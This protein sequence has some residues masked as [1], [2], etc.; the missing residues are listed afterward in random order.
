MKQRIVLASLLKTVDDPRMYYKFAGSISQEDKYDINIVGFP[1]NSEVNDPSI[2]F[3]A[4]PPFSRKSFKRWV[5]RIHAA[6]VIWNLKPDLL[7]ITTHELLGIGLFCRFFRRSKLIYDIQ[8]NYA[9]NFRYGKG[10]IG[11]L[12]ASMIRTM[13]LISAWFIDHFILAE[14]CYRNE[15]RF[16]RPY[17][18]LENRALRPKSPLPIHITFKQLPKKFV[19][20][21]TLAKQTGVLDAIR[22]IDSYRTCVPDASLKIAGN[23][24]NRVFLKNLKD[25]IHSVHWIE[26]EI[27]EHPI[28]YPRV[29][30][31]IHQADMGIIS[32]EELPF[33]IHKIPTKLFEYTGNHL[34]ILFL[35]DNT[36][37]QDAR[38]SG[39]AILWDEDCFSL[40]TKF[41]QTV[42]YPAPPAKETYWDSI[43]INLLKLINRLL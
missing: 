34:P 19:F 32:Y 4:L 10:I 40:I 22:M 38:D 26:A 11:L 25:L 9:A 17:T 14:D 6:R 33:L 29:L 3:H 21:G 27:S 8:E 42:F 36:W 43:E 1:T 23:S 5:A 2:R 37:Y 31:A 12:G 18:V 20:T 28:P 35:N 13:E 39:S 24:F 15:L 16:A 30:Q 41:E 7:I